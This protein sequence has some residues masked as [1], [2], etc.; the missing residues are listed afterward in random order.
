MTSFIPI[1][2]PALD[3]NEVGYVVEAVKSTWIS[4]RGEFIDRFESNFSGLTGTAHATTVANGTVALHAALL[5][6]G[7][8]PGDEVVVPTLTY[9]ASVNAI[10]FLGATPVFCDV[11]RDYWQLDPDGLEAV[12]TSRSKAIIV[13]HLYG[14][15]ASMQAV[16]AVANRHNLK[17]VEDC[18]EAL[19]SRI[20][21]VHVG[22]FGDVAIYSF[23]G[24]KT[25]TTGEG[26][27]VVSN[28]PGIIARVRKIK[29]QGL[30]GDREY[31][32]DMVAHNFRMTNVTAAI[33]CAQLERFDELLAGKRKLATRYRNELA[34]TP[35]RFLAEKDGCTSSFWM[36]SALA[37]SREELMALRHHLREADIETRPLFPPVHLMPMYNGIE[38]Q[39][40]NAEYL[41]FSG[42]NLPSWPGLPNDDFGRIIH[43]ILRFYK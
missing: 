17:I 6:L 18:A 33:G 15:P 31:W 25:I 42:L 11:E 37:R 41:S 24:N 26:G 7:L 39:F 36:V 12:I 29:S 22:N 20:G 14:H 38:G 28:D 5:A 19:G 1:Y 9:V 23:F 4:S 21:G 16:R 8:G 2:Q 40:P 32:H 3:G 10:R 34:K 35:L 30:S 27:M 13:V 43:S